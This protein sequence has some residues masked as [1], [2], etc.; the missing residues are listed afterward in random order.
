[1]R[2][3]PPGAA[4]LGAP[5]LDPFGASAS[6]RSAWVFDVD[7]TMEHHHVQWVNPRTK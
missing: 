7:R 5:L 3:T 4:P 2:V 1:M 6:S